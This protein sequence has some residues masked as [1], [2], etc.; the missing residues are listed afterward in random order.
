L[1]EAAATARRIGDRGAAAEAAVALVYVELHTDPAASHAK[2]RAK[3]DHAIRVFEEL[4]DKAA[5][6]RAVYTA[7]M[8]HVWAGDNARALAEME[9]AARLAAESGDRM[10]EQRSISGIVIALTYGSLPVD[11]IREKL[12]EIAPPVEGT[13]RPR[14]QILRTRALLE[15][16]QGRFDEARRLIAEADTTS[17]ELG[18]EMTRAAGVLRAAGEIELLAGDAAAAE[19]HFREAYETLERGQDWGHLASV[20]PLLSLALLA[21]A[22]VD[23]A[24]P[25]LELT[26]RWILDDDIDAQISFLRARAKLAALEGDSAGAQA[27]A[28]GAVDRA[29]ESDDLNAHAG[30]LVDL[31]EALELGMRHDEAIAGL[32]EAL[33]LYE[34]KGNVVAAE[35][36]RQRLAR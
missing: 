24:E 31:A 29:A 18:L 25:P 7:A 20:A 8:I 28:R 16:M 17:R 9:R 4:E 15:A 3:L 6:S 21:Q 23:E 11:A 14:V 12:D 2:A 32:R 33:E 30:A 22:R 19:R 26:A 13:M 36:V 1:S 10:Q 35:H 27:L 5:L 34:R